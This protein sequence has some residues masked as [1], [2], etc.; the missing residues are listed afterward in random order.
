MDDSLMG[1][2]YSPTQNWAATSQVG[3]KCD[4]RRVAGDVGYL[5]HS[6]RKKRKWKSLLHSDTHSGQLYRSCVWIRNWIWWKRVWSSLQTRCQSFESQIDQEI[7][8]VLYG[9]L[10]WTMQTLFWF[11]LPS[12]FSDSTRQQSR[13][14]SKLPV[15]WIIHSFN[16]APKMSEP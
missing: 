7:A 4:W 1:G 13:E 5:W 10:G 8:P 2:G 3:P 15:I 14:N 11:L 6:E 16:Y 12:I 9:Q